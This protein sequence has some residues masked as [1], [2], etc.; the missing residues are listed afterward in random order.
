MLFLLYPLPD[1]TTEVCPHH[2]QTKITRKPSNM[3]CPSSKISRISS[4]L[5]SNNYGDLSPKMFTL[6]LFAPYKN[7]VFP[8]SQLPD[9]NHLTRH[10]CLSL[11]RVLYIVHWF[12]LSKQVESSHICNS[13]HADDSNKFISDIYFFKYHNC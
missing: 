9:H 8:L 4:A 3:N 6:F 2:R 12:Y 11:M 10:T 1:P 5:V 13:I 7:T